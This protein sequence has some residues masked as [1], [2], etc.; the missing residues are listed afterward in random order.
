[1]AEKKSSGKGKALQDS[2]GLP[3]FNDGSTFSGR[4]TGPGSH[5]FISDAD[6]GKMF[7]SA[8]TAT[9]PALSPPD[10]A[11]EGDLGSSESLTQILQD[12]AGDVASIEGFVGR[13]LTIAIDDSPALAVREPMDSALVVSDGESAD[14]DFIDSESSSSE[15]LDIFQQIAHNVNLMMYDVN[16]LVTISQAETRGDALNS[17]NVPQD[18]LKSLPK[19][20]EDGVFRGGRDDGGADAGGGV[21]GLTGMAGFIGSL[22]IGLRAW[23]NP[24][25]ALGVPV[26]LLFLAG[27]TAVAWFGSKMFAKSA[28]HI[29]EGMETLSNAEVDTE[30]VVQIAKA[31]AAMGGALAAEGLGAA[32]GSIGS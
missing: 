27:L 15:L 23:G 18:D 5:K 4:W 10:V 14:T 16:Q 13:L 21:G 30:K 19:P 7:S 11:S 6:A 24:A 26:F 20:D 3:T 12:I 9:S 29:A 22:G 2:Y 8:F 32:L 28:P 31:L 1:M 25:T 17:A